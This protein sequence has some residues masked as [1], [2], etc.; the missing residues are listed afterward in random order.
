MGYEGKV[1]DLP[2]LDR[3]INDELLLTLRGLIANW[4]NEVAEFKQAS[5]DYKQDLIGQYFSALSNE[6]KLKGLQHS[7]LVF[8]V[9]NK[10]R[11]IVGTD[12]RNTQ[13]LDTLKHEIA[14]NTT[15]GMTFTDIFEVYDGN[16]RVVMFKIPAAV[17][18]MPTAWKNHWYGRE[19]E[20]LGALSVEELDRL[21]MQT[22]PDWSQQLIERSSIAHLDKDAVQVA[23]ANYKAKQNREHISKEVDALSDE[24]FLTKLKLMADGKLTNAAM[25]LLGNTDYDNLL[26]V[27]VRIMWRLFDNRDMVKDYR[28]FTIPYVTVV[29]KVYEKV[30]NLTYR[31][32]PNRL[33]LTTY[34][35]PQYD[36]GLQR[37]L[38]HNSIAHMSYTNG[39]RIYVDEYEDYI[40]VQN[41]GTFLPGDV[42]T[43]LKPWYTAPYYRNQL[44][45]E[46]MVKFNMIDTVSMGIRK[47]YRIQQDR[48]FPLPDYFFLKPDKV[49]V[50]VYGKVLDDYYMRMLYDHPE[51]DLE[52]VFQ[53]DRVQKK[54][55]ISK[56]WI[57]KLRKLSVIEGKAPHV[58]ISAVV[59]EE[60]GE[61]A[62]YIKNKGQNDLYYR[63]MIIDY[64]NRW[65][66]GTKRDFLELL[67]D[68]LPDVLNDKQKN[69]KIRN[70]LAL[71]RREGSIRNTS[72]NRRSAVWELAE[73]A[74]K[75]S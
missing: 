67:G 57:Q 54:L 42:R 53:M 75:K 41:P 68:K 46:T 26:N 18:A 23:R 1:N 27:P 49:A 2:S 6:A 65:G 72:P 16:K 4:E 64:L 31:Y 40:M 51:F 20:S 12:Y 47:I 3:N 32:I 37:E 48:Y 28:E 56:E 58:Y 15:C 11:E 13:G 63:Q 74:N 30:R 50:R 71:L 61:K 70:M 60:R 8:G 21:R 9:H 36:A 25:V 22:H 5:N 34:E 43:V 55:P 33:S 45:A 44:L 24:E 62:Q 39:G 19:G 7:W 29:D 59:A 73:S 52:T 69:D 17:T 35:L 38:L 14:Q 66:K 10:T